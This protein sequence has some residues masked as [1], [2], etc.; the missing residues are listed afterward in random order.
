LTPPAPCQGILLSPSCTLMEERSFII[1][2]RTTPSKFSRIDLDPK[3]LRLVIPIQAK[4]RG[5]TCFQPEAPRMP[6]EQRK[7]GRF[8]AA[9]K[10]GERNREGPDFSRAARQDNK[11]SA[12]AAEG[13]LATIDGGAPF[14]PVFGSSE[15]FDFC[16]NERQKPA[17]Q[18]TA[19]LPAA[20]QAHRYRSRSQED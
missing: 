7:S 2:K 13:P 9:R 14:K 18:R 10:A 19:N 8:S 4:R 16:G 20:A 3:R 11:D 17:P 15:D 5:G 6:T 12:S 1:V